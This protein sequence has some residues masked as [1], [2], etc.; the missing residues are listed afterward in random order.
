MIFEYINNHPGTHLREI[1]RELELG[2][3]DL[4]YH[5]YALEKSGMI[6]TIRRGLYKYVFPSGLFGDKQ[7]SI[8]SAISLESECKILLCLSKKPW[9]T[10]MELARLT[11][12]VP[13]TI[14][15][16]MKR[17]VDQKIVERKKM[18]KFVSYSLTSDTQDLQ[19]FIQNYHHAFWE[20]WASRLA[21]MLLALSIERIEGKKKQVF[22]IESEVND[23][24]KTET[25]FKAGEEYRS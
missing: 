15:W 16:H 17:L 7:T 22:D 12:L 4:Q 19:S 25:E 18:G 1:G 11:Q 8:L 14:V 5:I 21:D 20:K 13:A 3:G 2:M 9:L 23:G 6:K 10:Q 24:K